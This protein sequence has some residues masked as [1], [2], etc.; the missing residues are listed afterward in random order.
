MGVQNKTAQF[1]ADRK[2]FLYFAGILFVI[3]GL[4][5]WVF[6]FFGRTGSCVAVEIDGQREAVLSL[7]KDT[8]YRIQTQDGYNELVIKAG[9]AFV[10]EADCAGQDCV[11]FAPISHEGQSIVCLP[12][13]VNIY[14]LGEMEA[15]WERE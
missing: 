15:E 1:F 11:H 5:V 2:H 7:D 14:V 9:R 13:K 6:L 3:A 4:A 10:E 8:H 12:H